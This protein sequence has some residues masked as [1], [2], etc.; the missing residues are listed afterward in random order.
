MSFF[1]SIDSEQ[2]ECVPLKTLIEELA[3][4]EA[5]DVSKI[6]AML[7]R[8]YDEEIPFNEQFDF[9]YYD[10]VKSFVKANGSYCRAALTQVVYTGDIDN[11]D[12]TLQVE[13]PFKNIEKHQICVRAIEMAIFLIDVNVKIPPCLQHAENKA[14]KAYQVKYPSKVDSGNEPE[15]LNINDDTESVEWGAFHG[16]NTALM[17]ISGLSIALSA[18]HQGCRHKNGKPNKS[19]IA[20]VATRHVSQ[21]GYLSEIVSDRQLRQLITSALDACNLGKESDTSKSDTK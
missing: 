9:Y 1:K 8:E 6:A 16:K 7:L 4:Q 11:V 18:S 13:T 21:A 2:S 3:E 20:M 17:M 14:I 12:F 19:A 5:I 10:L 15:P